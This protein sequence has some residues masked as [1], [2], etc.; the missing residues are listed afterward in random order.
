M[1]AA[2]AGGIRTREAPIPLASVRL[3]Y[4]VPDSDTGIPRDCIL[5]N[6]VKRNERFDRFENEKV[7]DRYLQPQNIRIPWPK[8]EEP[9][10]QDE[11]GDTL[12][13]DVDEVSFLPTLLRPPMPMGVID[14]LR[15]K[16]SVFRDRHEDEYVEKK[17]AEDEKVE[18]EKELMKA[19]TPKGVRNIARRGSGRYVTKTGSEEMKP[20]RLKKSLAEMIGAH[21]ATNGMT[22]DGSTEGKLVKKNLDA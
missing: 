11:E 14:E 12:R 10:Y 4:P 6:L 5:T 15:G 7:W 22:L 3:V 17:T 18:A 19:M 16:F 20:A 8:K 13:I 9:E 21:M 2:G 1:E